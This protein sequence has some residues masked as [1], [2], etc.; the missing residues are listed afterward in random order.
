MK[1]T[2]KKLAGL[3][4]A[5]ACAF[6]LAACGDKEETGGFQRITDEM[7]QNC[8]TVSQ[9]AVESLAS[10]DDSQ[11]EQMAVS[12]DDFTRYA[13]EEWVEAVD[14]MGEYQSMGE[15]ET[16][17][18]DEAETVTVTIPAVFEG[19]EA[20]LTF[21]YD[22]NADYDQMTP[23]YMTVAEKETVAGNLQE[24]GINTIVGIVVVFVVLIFLVF[25]ISL[26][27]F[28]GGEEKKEAAK[29]E[30][31]PAPAAAPAPAPAPA[32]AA[33]AAQQSLPEDVEL[34]IVLATAIA[35]AEEETSTDG[36]VVRSIR[37]VN[38]SKWRRA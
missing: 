34:A 2:W 36:Y 32:Q 19:E 12:R 28:V 27:R 15:A 6:G 17:V 10:F 20:T 14:T 7:A 5:A 9:S 24:A 1:Q 31:A 4:L 25:V 30:P 3:T 16:A 22:Y 26:F 8:V 23:T 33:L 11:M 37:K 18:D 21:V 35:A 29:S 13:V 38:G